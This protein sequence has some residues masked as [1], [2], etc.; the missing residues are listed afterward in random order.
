MSTKLTKTETKL[1]ERL[2]GSTCGFAGYHGD[3][4]SHAARLLR[5]RGLVKVTPSDGWYFRRTRQGHTV[6][7]YHPQGRIEFSA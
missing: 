1:L 7:D 5:D 2:T 3:R 6:R 4:E